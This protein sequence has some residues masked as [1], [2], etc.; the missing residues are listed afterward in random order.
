MAEKLPIFWREQ[1]GVPRAYLDA[2][3][4]GGARR[5]ALKAEGATRATTDPVTAEDLARAY[6]EERTTARASEERRGAD[7]RRV[8][9]RL[10][11]RGDAAIRTYAA[12]HVDALEEEGNTSEQWL[13]AVA[14]LLDRAIYFFDVHQV[15]AATSADRRARPGL[16]SP[17]NLA[18]VSAPDVTAFIRW[19]AS[20]DGWRWEAARRE[21]QA[22]KDAK[23]AARGG[24]QGPFGPQHVRHHL[25][26]LSLMFK[27]AISEGVLDLGCNPVAALMR[28]PAVPKSTTEWL[29]ADELAVV[30]EAA[31]TYDPMR[32]HG[33]REPLTCAPQLLAFLVLTGCRED[34]ARRME[35]RHVHLDDGYL[36]IPGTKT[37]LAFRTMPLH[38]QLAEILRPYLR[39]GDRIRAGDEPLFP[40]DRTGEAFG[41]C[42]KALDAIGARAGIPAGRLR[43]RVLR[44]SYITHRLLSLDGG[45]PVTTEM[46]RQEIGH[47]GSSRTIERIY[48]RVQRRRERLDPFGFRVEEYAERPHVAAAMA[49]MG[50]LIRASEEAQRQRGAA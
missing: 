25:N 19:L 1:G 47:S 37:E 38:A 14:L 27:R 31:R 39:R 3:R 20:E 22:R 43:S 44:T 40:S 8:Q 6:V 16:C 7:S 13:D 33:G 21:E 48:A 11:L 32:E 17:R 2:R 35:V 34:E 30:L 12:H 36:E 41:D 23:R 49:R 28:K 50:E 45:R 29:E 42:R 46:V 24:K 18:T 9:A 4:W 10:G 5:H 26:V 15:E